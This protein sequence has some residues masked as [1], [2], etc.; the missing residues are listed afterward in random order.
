LG[1]SFEG[2]WRLVGSSGVLERIETAGETPPDAM[3]AIVEIKLSGESKLFVVE[4]RL[5]VQFRVRKQ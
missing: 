2:P 3:I 1:F 5:E 4:G